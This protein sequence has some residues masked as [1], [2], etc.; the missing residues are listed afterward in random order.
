MQ[1]SFMELR[2]GL[3]SE[4]TGDSSPHTEKNKKVLDKHL[5]ICYNK[6]VKNKKYLK[7]ERG[8]LYD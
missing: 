8:V 1:L 6:L 7:K 3:D 5:K 4:G 2:V